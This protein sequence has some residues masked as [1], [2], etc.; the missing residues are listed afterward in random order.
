MG[1]DGEVDVGEVDAEVGGDNVDVEERGDNVEVSGE[2]GCSRLGNSFVTAFCVAPAVILCTCFVLGWN[3]RRAV[4]DMRAIAEGKEKVQDSGCDATTGDGELILFSCDLKRTGLPTFTATGDFSSELSFQGVG[5]RTEVQIYQCVENQKT[6][7][8]KNNVGGG[9]TKTTT[10]TYERR[11]VSS[12]VD[13]SRFSKKN[14]D[15]YRDNCGAGVE[16]PGWPSGAPQASTVWASS[17]AVGP[18]TVP[19]VPFLQRVPLNDP[20]VA[21]STPS[22]W[23]RSDSE[24]TKNSNYTN[25]LGAVKA[26]FYGNDWNQTMLTVLGLNSGGSLGRWTASDSWL[27]SG[28]TLAELRVGSFDKDVL[29]AAMEAESSAITWILRF[30]ALVVLWMGCCCIFKPLEVVA[31]CVPFIGPYLG[32]SVSCIISCVT[33]PLACACGLGVAGVVWVVMRPMVGIPMLVVFCLCFGGAIALK[34]YAKGQKDAGGAD[35]AVN[36]S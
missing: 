23:V 12:P 24:Y 31:D 11:W 32:D 1:D 21:A 27:C 19:E 22:G 17:G 7:T 10:Y 35:P 9:T 6:T 34:V 18:Y 30:V 8:K 16:N 28:F 13:S 33:C 20:L 15:N 25:N 29:F 14:S 4:C 36:E 2:S 5:L 26:T 3:E